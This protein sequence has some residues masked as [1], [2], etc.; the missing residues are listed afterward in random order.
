MLEKKNRNS[1]NLASRDKKTEK[2]VILFYDH[3]LLI[4]DK[5]MAALDRIKNQ[6]R[7]TKV[8][9]FVPDQ[10]AFVFQVFYH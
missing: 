2:T 4:I 5:N 1:Y 3:K 9:P 7:I 6:N 10:E 8:V